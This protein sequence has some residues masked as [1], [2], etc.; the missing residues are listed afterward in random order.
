MND[1]IYAV[2]VKR[3]TTDYIL[4]TATSEEHAQEKAQLLLDNGQA[5]ITLGDDGQEIT[6]SDYVEESKPYGEREQKDLQANDEAYAELLS[7]DGA[8]V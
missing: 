8:S 2:S 4:V 7:E 5:E 6:V 1:K 3:E